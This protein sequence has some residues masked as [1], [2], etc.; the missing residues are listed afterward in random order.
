MFHLKTMSTFKIFIAP[1]K[2]PFVQK[3]KCFASLFISK[4]RKANFLVKN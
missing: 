3:R 1:N 4:Q 2:L